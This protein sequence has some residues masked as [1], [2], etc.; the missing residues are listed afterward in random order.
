MKLKW[1]RGDIQITKAGGHFKA[2][3]KGH[4]NFVFGSTTQEAMQKL[5]DSPEHIFRNNARN[6]EVKKHH[7]LKGEKQQ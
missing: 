2:R 7:W 4:A 1:K 6:A 5:L 3:F